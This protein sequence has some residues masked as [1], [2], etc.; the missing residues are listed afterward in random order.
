M[1]YGSAP[2]VRSA[3]RL[4][5]SLACESRTPSGMNQSVPCSGHYH[6]HCCRRQATCLQLP[7]PAPLSSAVGARHH[8]HH[9]QPAACS[10]CQAA[11][12]RPICCLGA[13]EYSRHCMGTHRSALRPAARHDRTFPQH[14]HTRSPAAFCSS[15]D[16]RGQLRRYP[17]SAVPRG[18]HRCTGLR[19]VSLGGTCDLLPRA[20]LYST[21]TVRH[22]SRW[23]DPRKLW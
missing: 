14:H 5:A 15:P 10:L 1:Q 18:P 7:A 22:I 2:M 13:E 12:C 8:R 17:S 6:R 11:G 20:Q 23:R 9:R 3:S 16:R 21:L 19:A 4:C